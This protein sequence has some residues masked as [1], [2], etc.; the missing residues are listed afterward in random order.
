MKKVANKG[1]RKGL[2]TSYS[3][4]YMRRLEQQRFTIL[5]EA[6]DW[7]ELMVPQ[8]VCSHPLPAIAD[9]W[10]RAAARQTYHRPIQPH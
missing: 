5:A 8:R 6:A 10:T 1:K 3:A 2:D 9:K 7:H 4:A